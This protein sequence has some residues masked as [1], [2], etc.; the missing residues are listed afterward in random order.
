MTYNTISWISGFI[1]IFITLSLSCDRVADSP[2]TVTGTEAVDLSLYER[3]LV[4]LE[5][6]SYDSALFYLDRAADFYKE[7]QNQEMHFRAGIKAADAIRILGDIRSSD[8]LVSEILVSMKSYPEVHRLLISDVY[9]L[10]G[11]LMRAQGFTGQAV[12]YYLLSVRKR[13]EVGGKSDTM[14]IPTYNNLANIS[15]AAGDFG[16]AKEYYR[17]AIKLFD[18]KK[19]AD[20]VMGLVFQNMALLYSQTGD[21]GQSD[22][23]LGRCMD[24]YMSVFQKYDV[25][26]A[27]YYNLA[28]SLNI[29]RGNYRD[30]LKNLLQAQ[31]VWFAREREAAPL[32]VE[33]Y[34]NLGIVYFEGYSDTQK[35]LDNFRRALDIV[36]DNPAF[37]RLP[38]IRSVRISAAKA[39]YDLKN[40]SLAR[41]F[42]EK[43]IV[44]KNDDIHHARA[45]LMLAGI[46]ALKKDYVISN[47]QYEEALELISEMEGKEVHTLIVGLNRYGASL[48]EQGRCHDAINRHK[49]ALE[50]AM[51]ESSGLEHHVAVTHFYLCRIYRL[52]GNGHDALKHIRAALSSNNKQLVELKRPESGGVGEENIVAFN[53]MIYLYEKS[54]TLLRIAEKNGDMRFLGRAGE[55]IEEAID[56]LN[57]N[58]PGKNALHNFAVAVNYE[59]EDF[60]TLAMEIAWLESGRCGGGHKLSERMFRYLEDS[61]GRMLARLLM[62]GKAAEDAL[63]PDSLLQL[64]KALQSDIINYEKLIRDELRKEAPD[65]LKIKYWEKKAIESRVAGSRV[66]GVIRMKHPEY[67]RRINQQDIMTMQQAQ[68]QL[69]DDDLLLSY[70]RSGDSV[71]YV[72]GLTKKESHFER[73][74]LERDFTSD[75]LLYRK[76]ISDPDLSSQ[77]IESLHCFQNL[78][79]KLFN[80]LLKPFTAMMENRRLIV[81]PEGIL[82]FIP[83][84]TLVTAVCQDCTTYRDL[85]YLLKTNTVSYSWSFTL[86]Q[87]GPLKNRAVAKIAAFAPEYLN[88]PG[89]LPFDDKNNQALLTPI[90]G[91]A[92]EIQAVKRIAGNSKLYHG[93]D[94]TV[95]NF[96][97]SGTRAG[98]VHLAMHAVI[99]DSNPM[100][101]RL[102]FSND[103]EGECYGFLHAWELYGME[104]SARMAVLSACNSGFGHAM[105]REG[106]ISLTRGFFA[107]GV[108]TVVMSMWNVEDETGSKLLPLFYQ[109]LLKEQSVDDALRSSK[110]EFLSNAD[111]LRAHPYFWSPITVYG[112]TTPVI[113][114]SRHYVL[115]L[116]LIGALLLGVA[117]FMLF[118]YRVIG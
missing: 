78:S 1:L 104:M 11:A 75:I 27:V 114:R 38:Y 109:F 10:Q 13:I 45:L 116:I 41:Q 102:V 30:A 65:N 110:L 58:D 105:G 99:D 25:Q 103:E 90:P 20:R 79:N 22:Y 98:V 82:G 35:S 24:V 29:R 21:Y 93:Q 89:A 52:Q 42:L 73:V 50:E 85:H 95:K 67:E 97:Q 62:D 17:K 31:E 108:P 88:C 48:A 28:G 71:L 68:Q 83:F 7:Q 100:Y 14:L 86:R 60:F 55:C 19:K 59:E 4:H 53:R 3:G 36:S 6:Q 66:A 49:K 117:G 94:A 111:D 56:Y 64:S 112:N 5:Q 76:L 61:K 80:T 84:E 118:R 47:G 72:F 87:S 63:V 16:Q 37:E 32:Q 26:L 96:M 106:I 15:Y 51:D 44:E 46:N 9:H 57:M 81:I 113:F 34:H 77:S 40:Y 74:R 12:D 115:I 2:E 18:D 54:F 39:S 107:A 33:I 23:Y 91:A 70:A 92:N 8:S 43:V 101:S 69:S